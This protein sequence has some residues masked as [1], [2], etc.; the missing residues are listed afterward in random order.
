MKNK[1]VLIVDDDKKIVDLLTDYLKREEFS[2]STL[3]RGDKVIAEVKSSSPDLI[4]LDIVLADK[5]GMTIC[6]EIRSFSNVPIL[7]CSAK[8]HEIDRILGLEIG[9]DDYICKPFSPREVVTRVKNI[10]KRVCDK[11][12]ESM[13]VAGPII[14]KTDDH[15]ATIFGKQLKLTPNEFALFKILATRPGKVFTRNDLI[16]YL[17]K[18]DFDDNIRTIDSCIKN[19]RKKISY[20]SPE[21]N[22]IRTF[23]RT[24]YSLDIPSHA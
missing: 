2:V 20:T 18:N 23:Y 17:K 9:A 11:Q 4:I 8:T 1:K 16:L 10:L 3:N 5:D 19:I 15:V 21:I 14:I 7:I 12:D 24:G 22:I 6:R 13:L